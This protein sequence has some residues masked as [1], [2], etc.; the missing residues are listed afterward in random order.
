MIWNRIPKGVFVGATV[1]QFGV[2]DAVAHFN[3]GSKAAVSIMD[4]LGMVPRKYFLKGMKEIDL[5][6]IAKGIV[7]S[8]EG[9][10]KEEKSFVARQK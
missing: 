3:I 2:Y 10:K 5:E 9:T 4:E 6:R 7:K 8:K 1:L